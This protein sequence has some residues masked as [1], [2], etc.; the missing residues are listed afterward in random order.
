MQLQ[1]LEYI[2]KIAECGS[3]TKAAEQLFISQPS[4]TKSISHLEKEYGI[5]IFMRKPR[6]IELTD[7]G[8]DFVHYAKGVLTASNVLRKRFA[9][10]SEEGGHESRLFVGTQQVDFIYQ[11]FLEIYEQ[12]RDK[13]IHYNLVETDRNSVIEQVLSGAVDLGIFVRSSADDKTFLWHTE[14][15]RLDIQ[16]LA[17]AAVYACAGPKAPFYEKEYISTAEAESSTCIVLD[18]GPRA[19]EDKCFGSTHHHF[20]LNRIVFFNTISACEAFLAETDA[21]LFIAKWAIGCFKNPTLRFF[22][23]LPEKKSEPAPVN[24]LLLVRRAG[25][26]VNP[27]ERQFIQLLEQ[28]SAFGAIFC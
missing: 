21:V 16:V 25:E 5:Q 18:M 17:R 28:H 4:L 14:A 9:P 27:T 6:G 7:D 1:Q 26:P 12:N 19:K 24:E 20:N 13:N 2:I 11:M 3:I 15:K 22:P 8:K 23:V 10:L